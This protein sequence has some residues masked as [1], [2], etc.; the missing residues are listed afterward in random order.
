MWSMQHTLWRA[1]VVCFTLCSSR[2]QPAHTERGGSRH[3]ASVAP[4]MLRRLTAAFIKTRG[5]S[6]RRWNSATLGQTTNEQIR[7]SARGAGCLARLMNRPAAD[8]GR[9]RPAVACQAKPS[10]WTKR[11]AQKL[12][13]RIDQLVSSRAPVAS[14]SASPRRLSRFFPAPRPTRSSLRPASSRLLYDGEPVREGDAS[15]GQRAA[16]QSIY[17]GVA[18]EGNRTMKLPSSRSG[19][20]P[21]ASEGINTGGGSMDFP[22]AGGRRHP[23]LARK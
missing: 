7:S 2:A 14:A 20:T 17:R 13:K 21:A 15:T 8:S 11:T 10:T 16:A 23:F 1:P 6:C 4:V 3:T 9:R 5:C 22:G 19:G 18:L 12:T